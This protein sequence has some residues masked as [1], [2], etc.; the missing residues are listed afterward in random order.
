M[1]TYFV[2]A[3]AGIGYWP[4]GT[5]LGE[6]QKF[7]T[8]EEANDKLNKAALTETGRRDSAVFSVIEQPNGFVHIER[9]FTVAAGTV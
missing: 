9:A 5:H 1:K 3:T 6:A 7:N 8:I 2:V 4:L